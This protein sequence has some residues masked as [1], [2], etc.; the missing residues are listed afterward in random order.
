MLDANARAIL[1][2][3]DASAVVVDVG[4]W[5]QPF[6]RAD[7]VVDLM[8]YETRGVFGRIGDGDERFTKDRWLQLDVCSSPLPFADHSVD[9]L[10][11]S[12][13]LEDIRDPIHL[14]REINRVAKR[15]Y[16]EVP[17]R[18]MESIL[19][20]EAPGYPGYY[21]HRWLVEVEGNALLFRFKTPLMCSSWKYVLPRSYQHRLA[22]DERVA[23]LFWEESFAY[24][25]VVQIS[26][27]RIAA[28]L[29][30]FIKDLHAYPRWRYGLEHLRPDLRRRAKRLLKRSPR[31]RPLANRLLKRELMVDDEV[32]FWAEIPDYR[33]R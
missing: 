7:Y 8:P 15:G 26:E 13:T 20:L 4:G 22:V 23:C 27:D 12:H 16:L 14:C 2:E 17:S 24:C 19:G 9:Y 32:R 6:T 18:Q 33:S 29:E 10:V 1:G 30:T 21:H 31:L 5:A 28:E 25:E 11:C 3:L